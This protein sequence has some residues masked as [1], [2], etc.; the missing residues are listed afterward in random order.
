MYSISPVY[1]PCVDWDEVPGKPRFG[2]TPAESHGAKVG[3][4]KRHSARCCWW[5]LELEVVDP[6]N[7]HQGAGAVSD[8][9]CQ[10]ILLP[11]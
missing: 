6:G 5:R 11:R 3:N 10:N 9:G 1:Q 8:S 7:T 4:N 2:Q